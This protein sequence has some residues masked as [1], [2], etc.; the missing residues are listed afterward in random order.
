MSVYVLELSLERRRRGGA[1]RLKS[2]LDVANHSIV[3]YEDILGQSGDS[4]R[5]RCWVR[6]CARQ[7]DLPGSRVPPQVTM[8]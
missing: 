5:C 4:V 2:N 8:Q 6:K 1:R 7:Q 3:V